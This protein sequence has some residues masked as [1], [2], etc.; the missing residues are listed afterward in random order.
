MVTGGTVSCGKELIKLITTPRGG[1]GG[2]TPRKGREAP[3]W[4]RSGRARA[5][6]E[7]V[8]GG[9]DARGSASQPPGRSGRVTRWP[10]FRGAFGCAAQGP[11]IGAPGPGGAG[12]RGAVGA[13]GEGRQSRQGR[14]PF[15]SWR[16]GRK[17]ACT[18]GGRADRG[19]R[20]KGKAG[21]VYCP[22]AAGQAAA[23]PGP[24]AE[25]KAAAR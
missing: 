9:Q 10:R 21:L 23:R 19:L 3:P 18:E 14:Q 1:A 6:C 12:S 20:A 22:A 25:L 8:P 2:E 7:V 17:R 11:A 16:R 15:G 13:A 4:A 5:P 24:L